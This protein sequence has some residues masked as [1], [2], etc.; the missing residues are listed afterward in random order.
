MRNT[1]PGPPLTPWQQEMNRLQAN[2]K[3]AQA[4]ARLA[5]VKVIAYAAI[6]A[7]GVAMVFITRD[8]RATGIAVIISFGFVSVWSYFRWKK[9][10]EL[11][12]RL[13]Q[14]IAR[15]E[16]EAQQAY[17]AAGYPGTQYPGTG[18]PGAPYAGMP[19]AG[20]GQAPGA[21]YPAQPD[22]NGQAPQSGTPSQ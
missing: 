20:Q 14:E 2:F 5:L 7:L 16:Q 11:C 6:A 22:A 18:A 21:Y 12:A 15:K 8:M 19:Y 4:N 1:N 3:M 9:H 17:P 10:S 13:Q